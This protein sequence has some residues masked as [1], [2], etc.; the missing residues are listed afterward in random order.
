MHSHS[1]SEKWDALWTNHRYKSITTL[2]PKPLKDIVI[3]EEDEKSWERTIYNFY[4]K[5]CID[6]LLKDKWNMDI[7]K[8]Y[9]VDSPLQNDEIF[10]IKYI[11]A[12]GV[13]GNISK[14]NESDIG[15]DLKMWRAALQGNILYKTEVSDI[16][17]VNGSCNYIGGG[18]DCIFPDSFITYW[19]PM[20]GNGCSYVTIAKSGVRYGPYGSEDFAYSYSF[21]GKGIPDNRLVYKNGCNL[22]KIKDPFTVDGYDQSP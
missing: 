14:Y 9:Y 21:C 12:R 11:D 22:Y 4:Q 3:Q 17:T 5:N 19:T 13:E 1:S 7:E 20:M 15:K 18:G 8:C 2:A 16:S 10:I 6:D